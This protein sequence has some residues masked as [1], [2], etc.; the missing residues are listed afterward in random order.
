MF[1]QR[2]RC[3]FKEQ[4]I[5]LV[6]LTPLR[7]LVLFAASSYRLFSS[8][9]C[10]CVLC[11]MIVLYACVIERV[12]D[13]CRVCSVVCMRGVCLLY[14]YY[15]HTC[16][17]GDDRLHVVKQQV[18]RHRADDRRF[19]RRPLE[20]HHLY[21]FFVFSHVLTCTSSGALHRGN[22]CFHLLFGWVGAETQR[23]NCLSPT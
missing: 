11:I 9:A 16:G 20:H 1:F 22:F 8:A 2:N 3:F 7:R 23:I 12:C 5:A 21:H 10:A 14:V 4:S 13:A 18:V 15:I 19:A 17:F 6:E